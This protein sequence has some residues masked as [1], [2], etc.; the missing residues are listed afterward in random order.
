MITVIR[1]PATGYLP[2]SETLRNWVNAAK[3]AE[4]GVQL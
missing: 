1:Q 2:G 4:A 3:R